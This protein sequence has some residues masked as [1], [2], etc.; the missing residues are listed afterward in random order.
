MK[1][2]GHPTELKEFIRSCGSVNCPVNPEDYTKTMK[3]H[4]NDVVKEL[5]QKMEAGGNFKS[6]A[7]AQGDDA[8]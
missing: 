2:L 5:S 8:F 1:Q 6:S 4:V 7:D 3:E